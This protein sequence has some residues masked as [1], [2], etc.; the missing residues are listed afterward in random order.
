MS[1]RYPTY[2]HVRN[3]GL[4]GANPFGLNDFYGGKGRNGT[5]SID[6]GEKL[7]FG[8]RVY[9]HAGDADG[10]QVDDM[11]HGYANPPVAMIVE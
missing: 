2:W 1:F 6:A 4:M 3:Y 10:G 5:H 11:F 8:Y 9:V 7:W